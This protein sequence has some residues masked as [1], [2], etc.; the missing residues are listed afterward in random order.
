MQPIHIGIVV[1]SPSVDLCLKKLGPQQDA[2]FSVSYRGF[3]EAV[4]DAKKMVK[5]GAEVLVSRRGTAHWLRE[6]LHVPVLSLPQSS[7]N[8]LRSIQDAGKIGKRVFLPSFREKRPNT[9]IFTE[10]LPVEF[11][12][13]TYTDASS[14]RRIIAEASRRGF[15][16]V[17]G[18]GSS[19]KFAHEFGLHFS[20][21]ATSEEEMMETLENARSAALSQRKQ[22]AM[23]KLYQS[24]LDS[25][26]DGMIAT[27]RQGFVT[28]IN[29]TALRLLDLSENTP[30]GTSISDLIPNPSVVR[31]LQSQRP[32][33]D[34]IE[35]VDGTLFVF[36]HFPIRMNDEIIGVVSS[37]KPVSNLMRSENKIRRALTRG[38]VANYFIKDLVYKDSRMEK[39]VQ[40]CN[41]FAGTKSCVLIA[42]ETGTGKEILAQSIHNLSERK[43]KPFV[44]VHCSALSEQLLESE[45]F[46]YE[47]G[48]FTGAKKGGKHGLFEL[49]HQGTIFLDEIDSAPLGVQ[50]R[51]L[52][53]LQE[54]EV[55]RVGGDYKIRIDVRVIA[56]AGK[57]LWGAVQNGTFRKDLFFRLNVLRIEIPPLRERREDIPLLLCYFLDEYAKK[58]RLPLLNI[59]EHYLSQLK[60]YRWPGNV[61]QLKHFAEQLIL[62]CNF[63]SQ[64]DAIEALFHQLNQ[65]DDAV[66]SPMGNVAA[67]PSSVF[68]KEQVQNESETLLYFL[69]KSCFN[70]AKAAEMLGISRTTL[71][72]R[73]K[74]LN[75]SKENLSK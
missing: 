2:R 26:S 33:E 74:A 25:S 61:R 4:I 9:E 28:I 35:K 57:D 71:W 69:Q 63:Q 21:L 12:Q 62:T 5:N 14:L 23:S 24:V 39:V 6:N 72:R 65:I 48:A 20:E 52:R 3:E 58:H 36:N 56:A 34:I 16:V 22:L 60:S 45:L 75:L 54:K 40:Y 43:D 41:Q 66:E 29:R 67:K 1:S 49:A 64:E 18:G 17:V 55:M 37:F 47:E 32:M 30:L 68:E 53:V 11:A 46:G 38:F 73:M 42:G 27:D 7:I 50:M 51:L 70:R 8:L 44:S 13:D 10:L 59:P 19:M 31:I 15:D